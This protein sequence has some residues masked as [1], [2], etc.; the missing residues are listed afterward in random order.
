MVDVMREMDGAG[1]LRVY[2]EGIEGG[3]ATFEVVVPSWGVWDGK[4]R[5]DC[6]FVVRELGVVV[7]WAALGF[8]S[9]RDVYR[10]VAEVSV[11]VATSA[12]GRGVGKGLMG[13]LVAGSEAAGIWTLQASIFPENEASLALHRAFGFRVVGY[14]ERIAQ[15]RGRW[16]DTILLERRVS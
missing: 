10:G 2:G 12:Q 11:Y 7:G 5:P 4:H 13:A 16:R 3:N 14:R 1:V 8:V 15:H 6:R 9:G